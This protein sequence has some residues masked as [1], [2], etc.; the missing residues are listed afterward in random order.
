MSSQTGRD[1]PAVIERVRGQFVAWRRQKQ[2]R[3]RIPEALWRSAV[4]AAEQ[5]GVHRVS[6]AL[7]LD[8]VRLKRRV[9]EQVVTEGQRSGSDAVFVELDGRVMETATGCVVEL[10]KAGGTRMRICVRDGAAV[11]WCRLKEAFLGA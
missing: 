5:Y 9:G 4:V 8:Y 3:E 10:E 7:G 1:L 6:R 2:G 11:D